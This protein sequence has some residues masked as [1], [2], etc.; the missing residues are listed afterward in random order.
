MAIFERQASTPHPHAHLYIHHTH[1]HTRACAHTYTRADAHTCLHA[2][3]HLA[4][5]PHAPAPPRPSAQVIV[6]SFSKKE[7]EALAGQMIS[8][9][10]NDEQEKKLVDGVFHRQ[11][12]GI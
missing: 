4:V 3:K 1:A 8:L 9:D 2:Q 7:C 11:A 10:L 6:F 12:L 5:H